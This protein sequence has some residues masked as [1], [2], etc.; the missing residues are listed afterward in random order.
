MSSQ[1]FINPVMQQQPDPWWQR[2]GGWTKSKYS[3]VTGILS[4]LVAAILAM[5][6]TLTIVE[7]FELDIIGWGT[8][9]A[10]VT[11]VILFFVYKSSGIR[12][13]LVVSVLIFIFGYFALG[14]LSGHVRPM[15]DQAGN[16]IGIAYGSLTGAMED[17]WL[18]TTNPTEYMKKRETSH[19]R[20]EKPISEPVVLEIT[21]L[22]VVPDSV[23]SSEEFSIIAIIENKENQEVNNVKIDYECLKWCDDGKVDESEEEVEESEEEGG[24]EEGAE[25]E[26]EEPRAVVTTRFLCSAL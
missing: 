3:S 18:L 10:F 26:E 7:S 13:I 6:D 16:A 21:S 25:E 19:V 9:L 20:A 5:L 22:T 24:E 8:L 15:M 2:A 23:P 12:G 4:L 11:A 14:P 17:V 1:D